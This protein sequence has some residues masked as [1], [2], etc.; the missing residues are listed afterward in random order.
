MRGSGGGGRGGEGGLAEF[1]IFG[2][3]VI[4]KFACLPVEFLSA[5]M[6]FGGS[7][8]F[9]ALPVSFGTSG[10]LHARALQFYGKPME[11]SCGPTM[12][13]GAH[14]AAGETSGVRGNPALPLVPGEAT[15]P[16]SVLG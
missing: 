11:F 4:W 1:A 6:Q 16:G 8:Q 3:F 7:F 12:G 9:P 15:L 5:R 2:L 13:L 10:P 14:G